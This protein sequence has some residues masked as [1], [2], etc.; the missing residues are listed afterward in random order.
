MGVSGKKD[1]HSDFFE[2][3]GISKSEKYKYYISNDPDILAE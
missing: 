1:F 3:P 2:N